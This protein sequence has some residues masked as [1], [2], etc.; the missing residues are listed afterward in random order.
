MSGHA[1]GP[2]EIAPF[3]PTGQLILVLR[4]I[5][6]PA[7]AETGVLARFLGQLLPQIETFRCER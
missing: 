4:Q 3:R 6:E 7:T 5:Q 2:G 1:D